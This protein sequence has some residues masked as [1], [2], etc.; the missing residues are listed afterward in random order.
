MSTTLRR[1]TSLLGAIFSICPPSPYTQQEREGIRQILLITC[2]E[3]TTDFHV[4]SELG[5]SYETVA[6][7][8]KK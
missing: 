2:T 8:I 5:I 1:V 7:I 4:S 3:K 6:F